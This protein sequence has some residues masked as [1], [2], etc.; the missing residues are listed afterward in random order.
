MEFH[1]SKNALLYYRPT[2]FDRGCTAWIAALA[3]PDVLKRFFLE[4]R[5]KQTNQLSA[6]SAQSVLA[7]FIIW[8]KPCY[9]LSHEEL[10]AISST[11]L[12]IPNSLGFIRVH[13]SNDRVKTGLTAEWAISRHLAKTSWLFTLAL[14]DHYGRVLPNTSAMIG[15]QHGTLQRSDSSLSFLISWVLTGEG[16]ACLYQLTCLEGPHPSRG[17]WMQLH[18]ILLIIFCLL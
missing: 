18:L 13:Y 4:I 3:S 16:L 9:C 6:C 2:A 8:I 17:K 15:C 10:L 11:F 12:A 7:W 14:F 5:H 1:L